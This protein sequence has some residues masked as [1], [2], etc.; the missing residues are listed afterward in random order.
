[1]KS[2]SDGEESDDE[3]E[4]GDDIIVT[5]KQAKPTLEEFVKK[6]VFSKN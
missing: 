3:A 1:M 5:N 4:Q 2:E 6:H